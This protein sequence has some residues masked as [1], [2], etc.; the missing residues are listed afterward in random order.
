MLTVLMQQGGPVAYQETSPFWPQQPAH[1]PTGKTNPQYRQS[2]RHFCW[3]SKEQV[4]WEQGGKKLEHVDG[5]NHIY[6]RELA[7]MAT[8]PQMKSPKL[9]WFPSS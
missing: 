6:G 7:R 3:D 2:D 9:T 4:T 5:I 8:F 1:N